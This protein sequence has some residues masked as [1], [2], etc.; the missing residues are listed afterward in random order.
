MMKET[1]VVVSM[2]VVDD[3]LVEDAVVRMLL[4]L[5]L[6]RMIW[7]IMMVLHGNIINEGQ[8][9][10]VRSVHRLTDNLQS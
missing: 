6:F 3:I 1:L 8:I 7:V 2:M 10:K 5:D 4:T 9:D